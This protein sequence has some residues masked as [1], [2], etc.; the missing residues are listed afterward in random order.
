[1]KVKLTHFECDRPRAIRDNSEKFNR[2]TLNMISSMG[3]VKPL[4]IWL[5]ANFQYRYEMVFTLFL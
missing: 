4:I 5:R 3:P 2:D 1:M